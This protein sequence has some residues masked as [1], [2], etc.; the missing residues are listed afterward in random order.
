MQKNYGLQL[1]TVHE[2][3]EKDFPGML[4]KAAELGYSSVEF[5]GYYGLTAEELKHLLE[6]YR[7]TPVSSQMMIPSIAEHLDDVVTY[8][9]AIGLNNI[10]CCVGDVST[11]DALRDTI[12]S[13]ELI[14]KR[15]TE[16]GMN[17]LYHNHGPE[18]C[19]LDGKRPI[20]TLLEHFAGQNFCLELDTYWAMEA[21]A[22]I[23]AFI[24]EHAA[25]IVN[26]HIKDGNGKGK[27]CPFG[28]GIYD[29]AG[30][31]RTAREAGVSYILVEDDTPDPDGL[32]VARLNIEKL[33]EWNV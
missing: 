28:N 12:A 9:K 32:T 7:L 30:I 25:R 33:K 22:D 10:A 26:I 15:L 11:P 27:S 8:A 24:K 21:G 3:C 13:L 20:D 19:L 14:V 29:I 17:F 31:V 23:C 2:E 16:E 1:Y 5:T 4:R 18:F 6:E